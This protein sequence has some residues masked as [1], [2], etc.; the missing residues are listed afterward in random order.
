[1]IKAKIRKESLPQSQAQKRAK[2]ATTIG[3]CK[4]LRIRTLGA[5]PPRISSSCPLLAEPCFASDSALYNIATALTLQICKHLS[6]C[7]C[8]TSRITT[9]VSNGKMSEKRPTRERKSTEFFNPVDSPKAETKSAVA[10]VSCSAYLWH[11]R[12]LL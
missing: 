9:L 12:S 2:H 7:P 1:M 11:A 3:H 10:E 8:K 6:K 4:R 5:L